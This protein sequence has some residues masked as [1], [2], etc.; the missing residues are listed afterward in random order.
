MA[1]VDAPTAAA[2]QHVAVFATSNQIVTR[3]KV[4][5]SDFTVTK[6]DMVPEGK[7]V[8]AGSLK[9]SR[10]AGKVVTGAT[11][12]PVNLGKNLARR[13]DVVVTASSVY[14]YMQQFMVSR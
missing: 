7:G 4:E 11:V 10:K 13:P 6:P 1:S 5:F 8:K 9:S 12:K 2:E 3:G 14:N